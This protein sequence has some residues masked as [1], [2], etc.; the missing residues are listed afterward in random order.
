[1]GPSMAAV[2]SI[3]HQCG[4]NGRPFDMRII[5]V[6]NI[7][8]IVN[9]GSILQTGLGL[10]CIKASLG[11][12]S[13]Q[14]SQVQSFLS[15]RGRTGDLEKP[16]WDNASKASIH[17]YIICREGRGGGSRSELQLHDWITHVLLTY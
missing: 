8:E 13:G 9:Q 4:E 17:K 10:I 12:F 2:T 16:L 5:F 3:T 6:Y 15:G 14:V 7:S 11:Y 1:V